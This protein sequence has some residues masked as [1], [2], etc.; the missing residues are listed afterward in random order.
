MIPEINL[1]PRVEKRSAKAFFTMLIISIVWLLLLSFTL[2]QMYLLNNEKEI[3]SSQIKSLTLEKQVLE[4][5]LQNRN[6]SDIISINEMVKYLE[7]VPDPVSDVIEEVRKFLPENSKITSY[8]YG[9]GQLT[10]YNQFSSLSMVAEYTKRLEASS[11][12]NIV[13]VFPITLNEGE[14]KT[15]STGYQL[16]IN[17]TQDILGGEGNE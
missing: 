5:N 13:S 16:Q 4:G 2:V 11:M 9:D 17:L 14:V 12:F 6:V 3:L 8:A 10:I 7:L 1:L 15:Y